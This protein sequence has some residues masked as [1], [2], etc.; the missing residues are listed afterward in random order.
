M[1]LSELGEDK[2]AGVHIEALRAFCAQIPDE[3]FAVVS[4][5][6]QLLDG[7]AQLAAGDPS[8]A[9]ETMARAGEIAK[10]GGRIEPSLVPWAGVALQAHLAAGSL[11]RAQALLAELEAGAAALPSRWPGAVIALGHAGV[12]ALR[13]RRPACRRALRARRSSCSPPAGSRWSTRRR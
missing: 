11:A 4:L 8:Q 7:R 2:R 5:W 3:Q 13:G 1:L 9:S 12:A 10:L 6:L